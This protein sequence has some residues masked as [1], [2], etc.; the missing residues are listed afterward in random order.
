M[1]GFLEDTLQNLQTNIRDC[2]Y[3]FS[4]AI[5]ACQ[6][7]IA[8]ALMTPALQLELPEMALRAKIENCCQIKAAAHGYDGVHHPIDFV[9]SHGIS[10]KALNQNLEKPVQFRVHQDFL[11]VVKIEFYPR[12]NLEFEVF[13][14]L[15]LVLVAVGETVQIAHLEIR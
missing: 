12:S 1:A 14:E 6:Y 2:E 13:F 9:I 15:N 4:E 11:R 7:N 8:H 10:L 3:D 5:I